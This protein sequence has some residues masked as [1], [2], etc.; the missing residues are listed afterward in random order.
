M[1]FKED[2]EN[3]TSYISLCWVIIS[4]LC[5]MIISKIVM[6]I[7]KRD[8][9]KFVQLFYYVPTHINKYWNLIHHMS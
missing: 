8:D 6:C 3:A 1:V 2:F 9:S 7:D 4:H 5:V